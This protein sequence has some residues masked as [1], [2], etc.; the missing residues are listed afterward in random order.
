MHPHDDGTYDIEPYFW[1]PE[2]NIAE[3]ERTDRLP[4]QEWARAGYI[5]LTPGNLIDYEWI[6]SKIFELADRYP[7]M[8]IAYDPWNATGLITQLVEAGLP[9][10]PTRQGFAT[11]S[12]PTKEFERLILSQSIRHGGHPV[13]AAH[14]RAAQTQSD[15]A[16][17]L[18]VS[19]SKST[20][21]I[22]GCVGAIMATNS[23]M[24]SGS[25]DT[26]RSVYET[27]G[28]VTT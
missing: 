6:K 13:L 21:R 26:Y 8:S 4:Y 3:R 19:K 9:C 15:P 1:M 27:R 20:A 16:G 11:M 22:D 23:A 12:A 28:I 5:T 17:N 18:K 7:R 10:L 25:I 14:V 2:H 24:L